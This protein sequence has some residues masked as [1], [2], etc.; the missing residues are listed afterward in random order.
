M[1]NDAKIR[2]WYMVEC[3]IMVKHTSRKK[4]AVKNGA[5]TMGTVSSKFKNDRVLCSISY[6]VLC[7]NYCLRLSDILQLYIS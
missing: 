3:V 6:K 2:Y 1:H 4:D 5:T 7:A